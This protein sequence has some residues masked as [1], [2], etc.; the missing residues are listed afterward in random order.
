MAGGQP[1]ETSARDKLPGGS[2]PAV[3]VEVSAE[4]RADFSGGAVRSRR[5]W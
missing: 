3:K 2:T 5:S 1:T 4:E